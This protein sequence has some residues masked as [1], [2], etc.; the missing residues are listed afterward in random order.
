MT[1]PNSYNKD[2]GVTAK[3]EDAPKFQNGDIETAHAIGV[4][5]SGTVFNPTQEGATPFLLR[6]KDQ[7]I[8]DIAK[9]LPPKREAAAQFI[10]LRSWLAYVKT[11]R[12]RDLYLVAKNGASPT[13]TAE[14]DY[15]PAPNTAEFARPFAHKEL[16]GARGEHTAMFAPIVSP[17]WTAW[18]GVVGKPLG[19]REFAEFL[20][21]WGYGCESPD[22]MTMIELA[23]T[24]QANETSTFKSAIRL[25]DGSGDFKHKITVETSGGV[26]GELS[27]PDEMHLSIPMFEGGEN[28]A[29]TLRVRIRV[30]SGAPKFILLGKRLLDVKRKALGEL[31]LKVEEQ[32]GLTVHVARG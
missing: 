27:V 9:F 28:L 10:D 17:E 29:V 30:V 13:I 20:D 25:K 4:R 32:L 3:A 8:E 15:L 24:L 14:F 22:A 31:H 21:E 5:T 26:N 1:T 6:H 2:N 11:F 18:M 23:Q 16:E 12:T 7:Q 19:Q